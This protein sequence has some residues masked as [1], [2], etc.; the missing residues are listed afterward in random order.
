MPPVV[1]DTPVARE[2]YG[3]AAIYLPRPEPSLI[4]DAL[5]RAIFDTATRARVLKAVPAVLARYSWAECAASVLCA[6]EQAA[7]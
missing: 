5:E 1:L 4:A 6:L 2:A 3:P 7:R